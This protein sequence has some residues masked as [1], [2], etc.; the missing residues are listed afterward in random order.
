MQLMWKMRKIKGFSRRRDGYILDVGSGGNPTPYADVL[1]EKY[2]DDTAHRFRKMVMDRTTVV[3]DAETMPF[4]DASFSYST[5]YHILEHV[6]QPD[7]FLNEL[8]RVS[9]AGYIETP[10]ALYEAVCPYNQHLWYISFLDGVIQLKRKTKQTDE[11]LSEILNH[12][13]ITKLIKSYPKKFHVQLDWSKSINHKLTQNNVEKGNFNDY[14]SKLQISRRSKFSQIVSK[15][16]NILLRM[17]I[18]PRS[19][20]MSKLLICPNCRGD[21]KVDDSS[22]ACISKNCGAI[23]KRYKNIYYMNEKMR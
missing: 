14:R 22:I 3:S 19:P 21:V 4:K 5:A 20:D 15:I 13:N 23:Y 18:K 8:T 10:N 11:A 9:N 1:L 2:L 6:E 16:G 7:K 17:L 12:I